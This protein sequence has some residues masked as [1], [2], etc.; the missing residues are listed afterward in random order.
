MWLT[1]TA[2]S[3]ILYIAS[4]H[5]KRVVYIISLYQPKY[6]VEGQSSTSPDHQGKDN[7]QTHHWHA[8]W[9][10]TKNSQL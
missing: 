10:L 6:T 4:V 3:V 7:T 2:T 8:F 9:Q 5:S 1:T